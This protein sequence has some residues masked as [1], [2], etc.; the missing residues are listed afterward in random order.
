MIQM[1]VGFK[2]NIRDSASATITP[3]THGCRWLYF[4]AYNY[5]TLIRGGYSVD[6]I[7]QTGRDDANYRQQRRG[8]WNVGLRVRNRALLPYVVTTRFPSPPYKRHRSS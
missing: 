3:D 4:M 5:F 7:R 2:E 8:S 6:H 1:Q